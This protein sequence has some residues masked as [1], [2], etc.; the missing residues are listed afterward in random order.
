MPGQAQPIS[1]ARVALFLAGVLAPLLLLW[2]FAP[3]DL[4][5]PTDVYTGLHAGIELVVAAV[6]LA[7]FAVQWFAAGT[8]VFR[9]ARARF[10][11]ATFLGVAALEVLHY[12]CFPGMPGFLGPATTER[13]IFYFLAA[14]AWTLAALLAALLM[15]PETEHPLLRRRWLF[16][17]NG[18]LLAAVVAFDQL[19]G[20]DRAWFFVQG[21]GLT[22][23]KKLIDAGMAAVALAG[24][25]RALQRA[26]RVRNDRAL[27]K[28]AAALTAMAASEVA[29]TLYRSPHD[30]FNV[31][32]HVY[33]L[34]AF[35]YL[36]DGLFVAALLQ[37]YR[38]LE[39]LR[40][41][42]E[43]ELKVTIR[44]LEK[45]TEQREDLLRAVS[46]D[47]RNPLQVVLLQVERLSRAAGDLAVVRRPVSS[48]RFAGRR[49][50]RMLRDLADAS[51]LEG[52]ALQLDR[53]PLALGPFV[54]QLLE[55][56]H[57]VL[58]TDRV[59][60]EV[61]L[62][63]P[64]LD[65]D[66][67]RLDRI[68]VNLVGNALKY[69]PGTVVIGAHAGDGE[70]CLWV[71]DEGPGIPPADLARLFERFY[72]GHRHEGEGLG[73][74]LFIV[75]RLVEAHGGRIE[76]ES[77]VGRGSTFTIHLPLWREPVVTSGA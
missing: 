42:V 12:L 38:E 73:L 49:M 39:R 9:E 23:A 30:L 2:A 11:A 59:R 55:V 40:A 60:N 28:V 56:E 17:W 53:A 29:F 47:L 68:L 52:G 34:L 36:F 65:V 10:L 45:V 50:E 15:G 4:V 69:S 37:P 51:R 76:A 71:S 72:R 22:P 14:R 5:L 64:P 1:A 19:A 63:L 35:W 7:T 67:D 16:A 21:Q 62:G 6:G 61:P 18:A 66:A 32:G 33:L 25:A 26:R 27:V 75:K 54:D 58:E 44:R 48:I 3:P 41:H 43:D 57:G 24:A 13:G 20:P 8:G 31:V 46:H 77:A 74:G 70:A